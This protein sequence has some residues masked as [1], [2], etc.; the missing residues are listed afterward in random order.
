MQATHLR[1]TALCFA[2]H[3][4]NG[5]EDVML[6]GAGLWMVMSGTMTLGQYLT[7]RA[8]LTTMST[9]WA[10]LAREL[11]KLHGYGKVGKGML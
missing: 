8:H 4:V 1:Q 5:V 2:G 11:V 3:F 9:G 6:L 7:F 10:T